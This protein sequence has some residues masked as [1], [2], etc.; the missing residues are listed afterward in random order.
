MP[1]LGVFILQDAF[2][3]M[4]FSLNGDGIGFSGTNNSGS[5]QT[6]FSALICS[7]KD[8][9]VGG[10]LDAAAEGGPPNDPRRR[11]PIA[12][13]SKSARGDRYKTELCRQF[14]EGG[15]CRYGDKCQFA[16]GPDDRRS[17]ARHPKYKTNR[18]RTFHSTGFCP[19]GA[20][21]HFIHGEIGAV[22]DSRSAAAMWR[23][24]DALDSPQVVAV[25]HQVSCDSLTQ[26]NNDSIRIRRFI[27]TLMNHQSVTDS[28]YYSIREQTTT[29]C[30]STTTCVSPSLDVWPSA[31]FRP[32]GSTESTS[33][34]PTLSCSDSSSPS[35][36]SMFPDDDI[37][38]SLANIIG[39]G[40]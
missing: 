8:E 27:E 30:I 39:V 19:Y 1:F 22:T 14:S 24:G 7:R 36:T 31:H 37:W 13:D 18:C 26:S 23:P 16:H 21:C 29:T 34:S 17:V 40:L 10:T 3:T 35:P 20:R 9:A 6:H 11:L 25:D 5:F 38:A 28:S 32:S 15:S 12:A 2:N 4:D 33:A